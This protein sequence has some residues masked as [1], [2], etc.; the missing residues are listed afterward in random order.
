M[1]WIL[2]AVVWI[3][4]EVAVAAQRE[5]SIFE[6]ALRAGSPLHAATHTEAWQ[7]YSYRFVE[8]PACTVL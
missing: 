7:L 4:G 3:S 5:I 6:L 8:P 1:A 2:I